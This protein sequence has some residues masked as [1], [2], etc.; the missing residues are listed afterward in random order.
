MKLFFEINTEYVRD[1]TCLRSFLTWFCNF[2]GQFAFKCSTDPHT[3]QQPPT[4]W[5]HN[6][7][8][9]AELVNKDKGNINSVLSYIIHVRIV[10]DT[11]WYV[12]ICKFSPFRGLAYPNHFGMSTI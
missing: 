12:H 6:E 5:K 8:K 4:K 10:E 2:S 7:S 11:D 3:L 1:I 9:L